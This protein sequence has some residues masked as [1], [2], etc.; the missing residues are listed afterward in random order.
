MPLSDLA[1]RL[2]PEGLAA[3]KKGIRAYHSSP[4][5]FDRFDLSKIGT[6]EG[7]QSFGHGAYIA[8][9]EKVSGKGGEYY[10]QF[11]KKLGGSEREAFNYLKYGGGDREAAAAL[12]QKDIIDAQKMLE[13]GTYADGRPLSQRMPSMIR[14]AQSVR[15]LALEKLRNQPIIGPRTYEVF[16]KGAPESYLDWYKPVSQQ[17]VIQKKLENIA[18]EAPD[19]SRSK[20]DWSGDLVRFNGRIAKEL[21]RGTVVNNP[22]DHITGAS[23]YEALHPRP[24]TASFLLN[25]A[26]V[27]GIRYHDAASRNLPQRIEQMQL[28]VDTAP[29][30]VT[31]S[32]HR[33]QL[34]QLQQRTPTSNA[35]VFDPANNIDILK[36]YALP[37]A[38]GTGTAADYVKDNWPSP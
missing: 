31:E 28:K 11:A 8:E 25:E 36:K 19:V 38:V 13:R 17:P 14:E 20:V 1:T 21:P 12:A 3:L 33:G 22:W 29:N 34:Q 15:E 7:A 32:I 16:A 35:V 10:N 6:G 37:G 9:S 30:P 27:P 23:A 24:D 18:G 26:G 4:H 2:I 5:D